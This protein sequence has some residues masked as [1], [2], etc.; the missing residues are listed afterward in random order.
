M[1]PFKSVVLSA[2]A[3]VSTLGFAMISTSAQACTNCTIRLN[4]PLLNGP[5]LQGP[6]LQGP[7]LQGPVLQGAAT[8]Q[9]KLGQPV[10]V[11]LA[12]GRVLNLK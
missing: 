12:N 3:A 7:V 6:V 9:A 2:V 1:S 8:G 4:G 10:S 5:V 11:K